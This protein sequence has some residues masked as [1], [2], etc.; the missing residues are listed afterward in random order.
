[1]KRA[2]RTVNGKTVWEDAGPT[3][4]RGWRLKDDVPTKAHR[5]PMGRERTPRRVP[6][7]SRQT[8]RKDT[9]ARKGS[10]HNT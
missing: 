10:R 3:D 4:R 9:K 7:T 2:I 5:W 6:A 1:M 8:S